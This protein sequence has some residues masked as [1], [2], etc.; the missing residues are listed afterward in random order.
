M[1]RLETKGVVRSL[2]FLI[3]A[4]M[5]VLNAIAGS[6]TTESTYGTP[7]LPVTYLMLEIIQSNYLL[8][9]VIVITVFAGELVWQERS[10]RFSDVHDALPVR[11]W[12]YW[13][14]KL[15]ALAAV[16]ALL[17]GV[18]AVSEMAWQA[19]HDYTN[20]ELGLYAR[21]LLLQIG[22]PFLLIAVLAFVLQ[23]MV[24]HKFAGFL[25][26][27]LYFIS[28]PIMDAM[29]Y[30]HFLYRF[31]QYPGGPYSDMN[32]F[33]HFVRPQFWYMLYWAFGAVAL[34][35]VGHLFWVRGKETSPKFRLA[36]ARGRMGVASIG[37]LVLAL[38]AFG[39]TGGFIYYNTSVLNE[40]ETSDVQEERAA[41]YE[42]A[43]KQYEGLAQP[44]IASAYADVD[45][46]PET[47]ALDI[48]GHYV[49]VNRT[50]EP[51]DELYLVID[52]R[53]TSWTYEVDAGTPSHEDGEFGWT[54]YRLAAPMN[55]GDSLRLG[56]TA[57]VRNEGFEN[58]VTTPELVAN[59]TFFNNFDFF[60][61][62]GY[63][64]G[65]ELADPNDRR[66][67][68][69]PER[70][71]MPPLGDVDA[72]GTNYVVQDADWMEF[73]TV[74]ST[75]SDQIALAPG[76]LEREWEDGGRSYFHYKMDAPILGFFAYLSADWQVARDT[77][78]DVEIAVY[79]HEKHPYNIE[80]MINSVKKSLDYFTA[81]FG[82]YQHRQV[83]IVEFP[84][85]ERFAQAFPNT[86]PYSES[87]GFIA[88]IEEEEQIDYVFYVT[89]HEVAHQWWAHQVIGARMQGSTVLSETLAQYSAMM[90]MEREYGPSTCG[91]F[92]STSS[93]L[94]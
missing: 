7:V 61:H 56:F 14:S 28:T 59:G 66:K 22:V 60:P 46:F 72:L 71:R 87:I 32:S 29:G 2:P 25:L 6:V 54:T 34:I 55:P 86:I 57:T 52:P 1:T 24:N 65:Q 50:D 13:S 18:G 12:L 76:Y 88:S 15:T 58:Q 17:L 62:I 5:G 79:H 33:G 11:G 3:M 21:G 4:A 94:T 26:M 16:L 70:E 93:I 31:A 84:R 92:S 27:L 75:T 42:R 91:A 51:V 38:A 90:V 9:V 44:R 78:N 69:L 30:S 63:S 80:R 67:H 41:R 89:A 10:L 39:A 8:F 40:H 43:Y 83:R 85:Y 45:I 49:L 77:W 47:R 73:E 64:P 37:T 82:P 74:V 68:D 53:T 19:Y 48:S 36:L 20:L 35:V 23:I 81:E